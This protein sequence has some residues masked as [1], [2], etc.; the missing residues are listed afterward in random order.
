MGDNIE[1]ELDLVALA[2]QSNHSYHTFNYA[3]AGTTTL[4]ISALLHRNFRA[5]ESW[6]T[7]FRFD[8]LLQ[9][10][11]PRGASE[12]LSLRILDTSKRGQLRRRGAY[13]K[14]DL[15]A[16][17]R[18]LYHNPALQFRVPGQ[19]NGVLAIMGPQPAE[20]VILVLGTGASKTLVVIISTA[21]AGAGTTILILPTVALRGDILGRFYK[22][23]IRP[24]IWSVGCKQSASLVIVSAEAACTQSFLEYC[25]QEVSK[26]RLARI[27]VDKG[28]LTI[29]ASDY[30][31]YIGQL[32][33]YIRQIRTQTVWITATLPP[34]M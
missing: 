2:E 34:V 10:K 29:T 5:S 4:T 11:R 27:I 26:Q 7:F 16:V 6:R 18:N 1:D 20:Q 22:V 25:H 23:G 14:A 17:A 21:I 13:S 19:R 32:G 24:L 28:Y 12:T 8:H 30:R 15:L 3:Y 33:W 31:P 9:G